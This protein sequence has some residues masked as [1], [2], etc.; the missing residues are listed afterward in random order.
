[1]ATLFEDARR[2]VLA[3][4]WQEVLGLEAAQPGYRVI[5]ATAAVYYQRGPQPAT[6]GL[7]LP[8]NAAGYRFDDQARPV[9]RLRGIKLAATLGRREYLFVA[10]VQPARP[11]RR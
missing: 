9:E 1:V 5:G 10:V 6:V 7:R 11:S 4:F 3:S 8:F 2:E